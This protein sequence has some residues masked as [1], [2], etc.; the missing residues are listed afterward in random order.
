MPDPFR[1]LAVGFGIATPDD[2]RQVAEFA[3][4]IIVGSALVRLIGDSTQSPD[5]VE[6]VGQFTRELKKAIRSNGH[7]PRA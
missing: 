7:H 4:G 6:R 5:L 1:L 3:D 2:A